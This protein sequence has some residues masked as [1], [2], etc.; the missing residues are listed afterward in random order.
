MNIRFV[1]TFIW[2]ARLKNFRTTAEKLNT[3]QPNISSRITSLEDYLRTKLYV[4]GTKEFQLTA[5]GRRLF[6]YAEQIV[7]LCNKMKED[8]GSAD[9][10]KAVLR[11]GVIELVTLSWFPQFVEAIRSSDFISEV[12]FITETTISL[13]DSLRKDEIDIAFAWGPSNEPNITHDYICNYD[14]RWIGHPKFM[15]G[16]DNLD[17]VDIAKLPVIPTRKGTSGYAM[18]REYF[19]GYGLDSLPGSVD[20]ITMNAF[21]LSTSAHL[22]RNGLGIMAIPSLIMADDL[23]N[24]TVLSL[25]VKQALPPAY[26]T[27]CYKIPTVRPMVTRVVEMA[28]TIAKAYGET[29]NPEHFWI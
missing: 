27:A 6:D 19:A 26:L 9:S 13:T 24:G 21:S 7:D 2:L 5:A 11:I 12:D 23:R 20:R 22:I 18:V 17:I 3:T 29:V 28:R 8:V 4:R 15:S 14:M 16:E 1:E 25:P 10:D